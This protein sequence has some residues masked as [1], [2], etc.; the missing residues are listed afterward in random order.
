MRVTPSEHARWNITAGACEIARVAP[1]GMTH[2]L[3]PASNT[4]CRRAMQC[5]GTGRTAR[6][7][8]SE[9]FSS[10]DSA[11]ADHRARALEA[12]HNYGPYPDQKVTRWASQPCKEYDW[13]LSF[14][15]C[16]QRRFT[17]D[18]S[19]GSGRA[20]R[21]GASHGRRRRAVA[22]ANRVAMQISAA[23]KGLTGVGKGLKYRT[24]ESCTVQRYTVPCEPWNGTNTF[25]P[26]VFWLSNPTGCTGPAQAFALKQSQPVPAWQKQF[27]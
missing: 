5:D 4:P 22:T 13:T 18:A 16:A 12:Y 20:P 10:I 23:R 24:A 27:S 1:I 25:S 6:A 2:H 11:S 14:T 9:S 17:G 8:R 21:G 7:E 15:V 3:A 19:G 26:A